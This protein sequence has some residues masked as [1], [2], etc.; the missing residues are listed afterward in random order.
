MATL[1]IPA[2]TINPVLAEID[3]AHAQLSPEAQKALAIARQAT[4][5]APAPGTPAPPPVAPVMP[6]ARAAAPIAPSGDTDEAAATV[7]FRPMAAPGRAVPTLGNMP[8]PEQQSHLAER[9]RLVS[10]PSGIA[11]IKNPWAR[12][13]LQIAEAV[14]GGFFPGIDTLIPGTQLHHNALVRQAQGAVNQDTEQNLREAQARHASAEADTLENPEATPVTKE[15]Q[16]ITGGA[17]DPAHPEVGPQPAFYNKNNPKEGIV[18]GNAPSG[19]AEKPAGTVHEDAEGNMWVV[20]PDGSAT[21]VAPKGGTQLKVKTPEEKSGTVHE[22]D[23]GNMWIVKGDGSATPVV[24]KGTAD[25]TQLTGKVPSKT[26]NQ[27]Q[28]FIDEYIKKKPGATVA[29]A[30]R[31]FRINQQLP[32]QR[33]PDVALDRE[34]SHYGKA[35]EKNV[36]DATAQLEKMS[37]ARAMVSSDNPEA[38]A[39]G[40]PKVLTALVSGAGSGVRI[41]Q[42]ELNSI[43]SARNIGGDF[44]AWIQKLS[45]GKGLT[46][47]QQRQLIQVLDDAKVLISQKQQIANDALNKIN[48]AR[49]RTD[50]VQADKEARQSLMDMEKGGGTT[51][52]IKVQIP[53]HDPGMIDASRKDEFLKKYPNAKVLQ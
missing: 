4:D 37:E 48:G 19:K 42:P 32:P 39:L 6:P 13:P 28:Q 27:E 40:I 20:H 17:I 53:G 29:E 9:N 51:G 34:T 15:W 18:F 2:S 41:T 10:S 7:P 14:G 44:Q 47:D 22:D 33:D 26:E 8:T 45:S 5:V 23:Q 12:I 46:P 31:A 35:H 24:P 25:G 21:A 30:Q 3:Q 52:Q 11:G 50:I 1:P 49:S 36:A 43:A 16:E 38:Q